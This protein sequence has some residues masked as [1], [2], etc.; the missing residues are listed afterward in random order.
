[1]AL[2]RQAR[3]GGTTT[4]ELV[5]FL[6]RACAWLLRLV[7]EAPEARVELPAARRVC[8][9]LRHQALEDSGG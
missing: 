9:A 6:D 4:V 1:T 5:T 3:L 8:A 7:S 2:V